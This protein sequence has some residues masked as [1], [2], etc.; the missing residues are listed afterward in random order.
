MPAASPSWVSQIPSEGPNSKYLCLADHI[1]S[2]VQFFSFL[3]SKQP[4]KDAKKKKKFLAQSPYKKQSVLDLAY[5]HSLLT[6]W[7]ILEQSL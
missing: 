4:F 5:G 1:W 6:V 2:M 7:I 3:F